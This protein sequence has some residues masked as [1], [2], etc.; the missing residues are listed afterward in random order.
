MAG[1]QDVWTCGLLV[2]NMHQCRVAKEFPQLDILGNPQPD[3]R[4]GFAHAS[5]ALDKNVGNCWFYLLW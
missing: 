5:L 1:A 2:F 4:Q 3:K